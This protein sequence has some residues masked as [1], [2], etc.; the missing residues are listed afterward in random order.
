MVKLA[1]V[2]T[3][4]DPDYPT[5]TELTAGTVEDLS[6]YLTDS[7]LNPNTTEDTITDGR[8]CSTQNFT[9]PGRESNTVGLAYV[10]NPESAADD[11]ARLTL[12]NRASGY[13]VARWGTDYSAAFAAGDLVDVYPVQMGV[14]MK[15]P[16]TANTPLTIAQTAYVRAPG[17]TRDV[18]VVSS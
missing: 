16:P 17:V 1:W 18:T 5:V 13:L 11:V 12:V 8:L 10:Y 3:I 4:M 9:R 7:G 2:P 6:C 14:Q 15:Q